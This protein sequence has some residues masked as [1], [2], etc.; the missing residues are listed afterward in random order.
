LKPPKSQPRMNC[1]SDLAT[2]AKVGHSFTSSSVMPCTAVA[3]SGM[4]IP[5]LRRR[6]FVISSPSGMTLI[7]E[8]STMR[9]FDVS[10]PVVSRSKKTMG[11]LRL[12]FISGRSLMR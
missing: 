8:I 5:G 11:R 10:T 9:S 3:S 7:S 2:C 6:V 12:S 4:C 1:S